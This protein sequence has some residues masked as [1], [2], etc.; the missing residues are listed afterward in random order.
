VSP[1]SVFPYMPCY[2]SYVALLNQ[3]YLVIPFYFF[4]LFSGGKFS[5]FGE[6]KNEK[7]FLG[8]IF[9]FQQNDCHFCKNNFKKT[10]KLI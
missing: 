7:H 2:E 4:I 9:L 6:N 10:N 3:L 5:L 8:D 1:N